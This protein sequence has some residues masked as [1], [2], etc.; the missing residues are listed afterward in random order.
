MLR[1]ARAQSAG[2]ASTR[3]YYWWLLLALFLE[4]ARPTTFVPGLGALPL[5]SVVPLTL[6]LVC[7]FSRNLRPLADILR[8]PLAKWI[9]VY[10]VLIALS[11]V[12]ADVTM[13][14]Y[15]VFT[16][17]MGYVFFSFMILRIVTSHE[18]M[19]GVFA[20]LVVA[21]L[22]LLAMNPE[23]V[24]NSEVR[25][26]IQGATFLGDGNDFS[27]SVC[28]LVPMCIE[29]AK[30]ARS[31]W[32]QLVWW[33]SL[34]VLLVALVNTQS[35]GAT[36]GIIAVGGYLWLASPHKGRMI[37]AIAIAAVG[38]LVYA[39]DVYF[40]RMGTIAHY[41]EEGSAMGRIV[42]WKAGLRMMAD[43][44]LLGVGAGHYGIAFGTIYRPP[45][46]GPMPWLT[47]HSMYFLVIGE[48]GLP[49]IVTLLVLTFGNL[50]A[51]RRLRRALLSR[52]ADP[53]VAL[54]PDPA[55]TLYMLNAS[56]VGLMV[57][58]AFL[59]VAYYPHVF[60]L[61]ALMIAYRRIVAASEHD[62][63][64]ARGRVGRSGR[65]PR[66]AIRTGNK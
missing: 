12:H 50:L 19:L 9:S 5:N 40:E 6:L 64:P 49:G 41:Q 38:V 21:H 53:A 26:Y 23:V 17:V 39:P 54:G 65:H 20:T 62:A 1:R 13:N 48:L 51:N 44:P 10:F 46:L 36:L 66:V 4:Y 47:A 18:R 61:G 63:E 55:A 52:R 3:L 56:M 11:M 28:I 27:L 7:I 32:K 15:N 2:D 37:V 59:S 60:V 8:D 22:F 58:G 57:A 33:L 16:W 34:L 43:N 29:L 35:R 24:M 25:N 31:K 14:A 30:A 42:A 45:D